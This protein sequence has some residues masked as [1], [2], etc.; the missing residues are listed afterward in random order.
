VLAVVIGNVTDKSISAAL[1]MS[2]TMM[3]IRNSARMVTKSEGA[4]P[5][6]VFEAV[7]DILYD[8]TE[9]NITVSAFM[10]YLDLTNGELAY[11]NAGYN[12]PIIKQG[13]GTHGFMKT[14]PSVV[15]AAA[16]SQPF[17]KNML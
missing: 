11:V 16:K 3:L 12:P 10:G 6:R 9:A 5:H 8:T 7:N 13:G 15:L 4:A 17:D 1:L 2:S 14:S